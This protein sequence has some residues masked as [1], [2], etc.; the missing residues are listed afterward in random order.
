MGNNSTTNQNTTSEEETY[1]TGAGYDVPTDGHSQEFMEQIEHKISEWIDGFGKSPSEKLDD[2]EL[3]YVLSNME[4]SEG[5]EEVPSGHLTRA[6]NAHHLLPLIE[7]GE[8]GV[9]DKLPDPSRLRA[10]SRTQGATADYCRHWEY[11]TIIYRTNNNT[12]H[13][14]ATKFND[15]YE[16]KERESFVNQQ[17][18]KIDKITTYNAKDYPD[19]S[20]NIN[21]SR[22][23]R[24]AVA[25][26]LGLQYVPFDQK[27][28]IIIDVSPSD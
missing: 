7:S 26:D 3:E 12:P 27:R 14:V 18:M 19:W 15:S 11:D 25:E 24:R 5:N 6:E 1:H 28:I 4:D 10:Y 17:N 8:I 9:G 23:F 13:F 2:D 21:T 16:F 22:E 20:D